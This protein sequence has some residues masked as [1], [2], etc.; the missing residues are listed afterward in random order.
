M[1]QILLLLTVLVG[2]ECQS[3]I[4]VEQEVGIVEV[5]TFKLKSGIDTEEGKKK[6]LQLNDC[7]KHFDGFIERKLTLNEKGEWLD[8]V[9]WTSKR[10]AL[11]AAEEVS[12]DPKAIEFFS[13]I[14]E[15]TIVM[16]HYDLIEKFNN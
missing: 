9:Y 3:Q 2:L 15:S 6:L 4:K 11:N 12:K 1:K 13:V 8:I 10:A 7:V 14:D 16:G 5:V